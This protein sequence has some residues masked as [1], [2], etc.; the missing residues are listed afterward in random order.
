MSDTTLRSRLWNQYFTDGITHDDLVINWTIIGFFGFLALAFFS[1]LFPP[2]RNAFVVGAIV[3]FVV[4]VGTHLT[5]F[6]VGFFYRKGILGGV[7]TAAFAAAAIVG[8]IVVIAVA[9][10]GWFPILLAVTLVVAPVA[11]SALPAVVV[12]ILTPFA[13]VAT[14]VFALAWYA[15]ALMLLDI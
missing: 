4:G 15:K 3:W 9:L 12:K 8:F 14:V 13:I 5:L 11:Q 1:M 7:A 10:F 2:V 6:T